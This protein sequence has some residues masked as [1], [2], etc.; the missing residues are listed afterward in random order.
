MTRIELCG[1]STLNSGGQV[2]LMVE[3]MDSFAILREIRN[4]K[5]KE[6]NWEEKG[7]RKR[8]SAFDCV[9]SRFWTRGKIDD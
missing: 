5:V 1:V 6:K 3:L 9:M 4:N 2:T 8:T 7:R